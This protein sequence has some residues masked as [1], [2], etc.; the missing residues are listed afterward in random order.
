MAIRISVALIVILLYLLPLAFAG[1]FLSS[2]DDANMHG[3]LPSL[4]GQAVARNLGGVGRSPYRGDG[5]HN[6]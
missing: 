3:P 6:R 2:G 1:H 4:A 5:R